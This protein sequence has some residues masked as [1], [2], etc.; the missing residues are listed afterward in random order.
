ML[1]VILMVPVMS[2]A[3][4]PQLLQG[5]SVLVKI[6]A[7]SGVSEERWVL[8]GL[9]V[10]LLLFFIFKSVA[11]IWVVDRRVR[12]AY[13]VAGRLSENLFFFYMFRSLEFHKETPA[14]DLV[15][16]TV[17]EPGFFASG[18]I[19]SLVMLAAEFAVSDLRKR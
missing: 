15:Q 13:R 3:I 5:H 11:C 10:G 2:V 8:L 7:W 4:Q 17:N 1:D 16:R 9:L 6:Q 12:F 14:M 19:L 18:V